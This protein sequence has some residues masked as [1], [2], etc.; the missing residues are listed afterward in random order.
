MVTITGPEAVTDDDPRVTLIVFA[1]ACWGRLRRALALRC[2]VM[3]RPI[4]REFARAVIGETSLRGTLIAD[5]GRVLYDRPEGA[6]KPEGREAERVCIGGGYIDM[7]GE[8]T[9]MF[10]GGVGIMGKEVGIVVGMYCETLDN[11]G[12]IG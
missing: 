11:E 4:A 12:G 1:P 5:I 3:F 8:G 7:V 2:A 9:G 10:D 6:V